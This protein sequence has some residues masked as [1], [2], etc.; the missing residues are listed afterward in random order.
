MLYF[1]TCARGAEIGAV[2]AKEI[3]EEA[4]GL[5]WTVPNKKNAKRE[6]ATVFRVLLVGRAE[7]I[8]KRRLAANPSGYLFPSY[9]KLGQWE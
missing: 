1:W 4:D 6:D 7:Q 5:W 3:S 8:A 2:E 9:R